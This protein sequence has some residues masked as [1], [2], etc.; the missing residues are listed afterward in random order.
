MTDTLPA[1][2]RMTELV[3]ENSPDGITESELIDRLR[4]EGHQVGRP[5]L[6]A[7]VFDLRSA[8]V[9]VF[10][11]HGKWRLATREER[12][13][14]EQ[15]RYAATETWDYE[16]TAQAGS[17]QVSAVRALFANMITRQVMTFTA[18][19]FASFRADLG[20]CGITLHEVT[21]IP[22]FEPEVIG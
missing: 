13:G 18:A 22:H 16:F 17:V 11:G 19:E 9:A 7:W 20:G 15:A 6:H 8:G 14:A 12:A 2:Q 21:R 3:R 1:R 10:T 5:E 4:S